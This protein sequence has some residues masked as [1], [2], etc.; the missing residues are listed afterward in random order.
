MLQIVH[1]S[2]AGGVKT[3]SEIIRDGLGVRD[4]AIETAVMFPHPHAGTLA[5]LGGTW[6]VARQVLAGQYDTIIAYQPTASILTGLVGWIARCPLRIVHQTALPSEVRASLRW[7]D[8]I[9]GTFGLYTANVVNSRA[10]AAA[11][12]RYPARYQRTMTMI[13]HG[14]PMPPPQHS[15][16][17]TLK[18]FGI[19]HDRRVL[20]NTGRLTNQ[21]NQSVLIRALAQVSSVRLVVAGEGPLRSEYRAL[22]RQLGVA[23]RLHLLGDVTR[24]DIADLLAAADLFVFPSTWE[25]FGLAAVEAL[26]AGLPIVASDL[27]VLREVLSADG[28]A[29]AAFAPPFDTTAWARAIASSAQPSPATRDAIAQRYSVKRMIDAYAALLGVDAN[30]SRVQWHGGCGAVSG[31]TA[32][33]QRVLIRGRSL[34]RGVS[35]E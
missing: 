32:R 2:E 31:S 3:L 8:R 34:R 4:I 30:H 7:F 33:A 25:T 5:K 28:N 21:K 1:G 27:P 17:D 23:D 20:L 22:A 16:A 18:R 9:L 19:P 11:F 10:T 14:V 12:L 35:N 15:G 24:D 29:A 13:E 6:R 26:M